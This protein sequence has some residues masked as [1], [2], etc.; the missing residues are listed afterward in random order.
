M[1]IVKFCLISWKNNGYL[2]WQFFYL[3][4]TMAFYPHLTLV[5]GW[6]YWKWSRPSIHTTSYL[7]YCSVKFIHIGNEHGLACLFEKI[8]K[9]R[10]FFSHFVFEN[11]LFIII[12][13]M[14]HVSSE[15]IRSNFV[16]CYMMTRLNPCFARVNL[17]SAIRHATPSPQ[18]MGKNL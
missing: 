8:Y 11:I 16:K 10:P 9:N 14:Y 3:Y 1:W 12:V 18:T 13:S 17:G 4:N 6:G 5:T 7:R 2:H 15:I